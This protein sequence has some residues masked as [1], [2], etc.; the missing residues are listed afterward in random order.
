MTHVQKQKGLIGLYLTIV[1]LVLMIG[2]IVS[3]GFGVLA[4]Q[5]IIQNTTQSAQSYFAA[6]SGAE[7]ALL[8]LQ[9]GLNACN[10][11]GSPPC[12]NTLQVA[13]ASIITT[14]SGIVGGARTITAE[15][16]LGDRFRTVQIA[17]EVSSTGV[18]FFYGAQV[19]VGGLQMD[20]NAV[21][22]GNVFSNG[23]VT[24]GNGSNITGT[25][26]VAGA[27]K[28]LNNVDIGV[29]AYVDI[30]ENNGTIVTGVLHANTPGS[31]NYGSLTGSGLP[32]LPIPLPIADSQIQQWKD[33][34]AAGGT[35]IGNY[36][37]NGAAG[38]LGPRKITGELIVDNNAVLTVTGTLWVVG[39]VTIKNGSTIKLSSGYGSTSGIII[40]D[41]LVL[42]NNNSVSTGSG[43]AGSY[44]MYISTSPSLQAIEVRQ[45]NTEATIAYTNTGTV[46][47][48]NGANLRDAVAYR[49]HI[50]QNATITYETGL[51]SAVFTSGP[52][53]GWV[54][55][56]WKEIE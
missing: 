41:S 17:H 24:G 4:Q 52:G 34:A 47:L 48:D 16:D 32:I 37:L 40:S 38:S 35:I 33:E 27:G 46:L 28:K 51:Q 45:G 39:N 43:Q 42:L 6:E 18:G 53:G 55:T 3:I 49:L 20:N 1:V 7:D 8:R 25:L 15:G 13:N 26:Q 11:P 36:T 2:I 23:N 29:D 44:L 10:P 5:K 31:C 9:K 54:V 56:G 14:I 50:K 22:N 21:V 19:G 30:C 12:S